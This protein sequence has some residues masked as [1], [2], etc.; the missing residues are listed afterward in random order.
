MKNSA[1][2]SIAVIALFL[3]SFAVSAQEAIIIDHTCTD[4]TQIP[5][6]WIQAAKDDLLIGYGHTSHGSQLVTGITAFEDAL[7]G[8][9]DFDMSSY[10]LQVGVFLNDTWAYGDLGHNGDLTWRDETVTMLDDP[11]NDRNVVMWSWCG[12]CSDNTEEGI[13]IYLNAMNQ[14]ELDYPD[15]TFI[16][17]TGHLDGTGETGNLNIRNDQIRAYCQAN[18]KVLF[19]FADIESYDPDG[20]TNYMELYC[21]D[22]CDYSG[23]NWAVNWLSANPSS[24]LASISGT[25][26]SCAHSQA[27]NCVLKGAA[28]WWM[29]ARIAGWD[30][31]ALS[32]ESAVVS[33]E[34]ASFMGIWEYDH[35]AKGGWNCLLGS[36]TAGKMLTGDI[37]GDGYLD[38]VASLDGYGLYYYSPGGSWT[39]ITGEPADFALVDLDGETKIAASFGGDGLYIWDYSLSSWTSLMNVPADIVL[40]YDRNGDG[41]D[42]LA[43]VFSGFDGLYYYSFD[44]ETW[45]KIIGVSPEQAVAGDVSGDGCDELACSFSGYGLYLIT[46]SAVSRITCGTPDTGHIM[47][48]GN[49][50]GTAGDEIIM[51]YLNRTYCYSYSAGWSL[52]VSAPLKRS[53]AGSFTGQEL[54]D[55]IACETSSGNIYLFDSTLSTWQLLLYDAG[56]NAMAAY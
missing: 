26:G 40:A 22:N 24:E 16:Y 35:D 3:L 51:T 10:G 18:G 15:V 27:L 37:T 33:I 11:D 46:Q 39:A 13:N 36:A 42:E 49:I 17:M 20:L 43:A 28:M 53:I 1:V 14:L 2:F 47:T 21:N 12:G 56:T 41:T 54:E 25:C 55:L 8:I 32:A 45:V 23:G 6:S 52:L 30:G 19:D 7:G 9:W 48:A 5:E 34:N 50:S 29:L 31:T 44:T 4:Y 38:I